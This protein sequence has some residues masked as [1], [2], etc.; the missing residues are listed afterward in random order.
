MQAPNLTAM[1]SDQYRA[2]IALM[3]GHIKYAFNTMK[4]TANND[5]SLCR[6]VLADI[7]AQTDPGF[8]ATKGRPIALFFGQ[9]SPKKINLVSGWTGRQDPW[10]YNAYLGMDASFNIAH[11]G[12]N[13][14]NGNRMGHWD[15][16][17]DGTVA[18]EGATF[19]VIALKQSYNGQIRMLTADNDGNLKVIN[20]PIGTPLLET[21]RFVITGHEHA[22]FLQ[23]KFDFDGNTGNGYLRGHDADHDKQNNIDTKANASTR[24]TWRVGK[25]Q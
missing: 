19:P 22:A 17:M 9:E 15:V 5:S 23:L 4:T 3:A 2:H 20:T 13:F 7:Q 6:T 8:D 11:Y 12:I 10:P 21:Q 14:E 24:T 1:S 25:V 18:R 16:I